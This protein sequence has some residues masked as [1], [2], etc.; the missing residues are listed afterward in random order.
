VSTAISDERVATSPFLSE[1]PRS[2]PFLDLNLSGLIDDIRRDE[3]S[4]PRENC[5]KRD[6][7]IDVIFTRD[8]YARERNCI[9]GENTN[10]RRL[11]IM[12][13]IKLR[14]RKSIKIL[15]EFNAKLFFS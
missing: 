10:Q 12:L 13:E 5:A 14:N 6:Y 3:I 9:I 8:F 4:L 2:Y 7:G 15:I 11:S 1:F